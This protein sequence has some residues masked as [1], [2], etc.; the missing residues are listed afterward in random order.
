MSRTRLQIKSV[1]MALAQVHQ[2]SV[3]DSMEKRSI[4]RNNFLKNLKLMFFFCS[5][6]ENETIFIFLLEILLIFQIGKFLKCV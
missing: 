5:D 6:Y 4:L 3:E 2:M 1:W